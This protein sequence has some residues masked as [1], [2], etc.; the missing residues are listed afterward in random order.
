MGLIHHHAI[1]ATTWNREEAARLERWGL[2]NPDARLIVAGPT[3]V[4]SYFTIIMPPDGS[5]EGWDESDEGDRRR[6]KLIAAFKEA[7]YEDRSNP[8][9]WVEVGYGELGQ[10]V[11]RGNNENC[12]E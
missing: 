4:N 10:E 7:D 8:W 5:K 12:Y 2:E 11:T 1:I 3:S 9:A 6:E